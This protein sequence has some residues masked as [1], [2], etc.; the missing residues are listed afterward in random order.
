MVGRSDF[1]LQTSNFSRYL[2]IVELDVPVEI[3]APAV[4]G[5]PETNGNA[6]GRSRFGALGH[7]QKMHAG[8][9][10]RAPTLLA[11]ARDAARHDAFPIYTAALGARHD[12]TERQIVA[13]GRVGAA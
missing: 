9:C 5:V 7:P 4:G 13:R 10:R 2:R 8:F 6:D 1:K 11:V 12:V 3:V